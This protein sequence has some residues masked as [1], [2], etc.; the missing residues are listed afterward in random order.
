LKAS[1]SISQK[2]TRYRDFVKKCI[3]QSKEHEKTNQCFNAIEH[4]SD[5]KTKEIK[6]NLSAV[7]DWIDRN[8]ISSN[9]VLC[10]ECLQVYICC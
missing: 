9:S 3:L 5:N 1:T 8:F 4:A 10:R 6:Q 2:K 7:C